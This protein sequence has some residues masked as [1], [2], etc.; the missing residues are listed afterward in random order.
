MDAVR[1]FVEN[2]LWNRQRQFGP[3]TAIGFANAKEGL[4]A[5]IIYH[6]FDPDAGVIEISAYSMR[7]DWLSRA[8]LRLIFEY[9]FHQIKC[10]LVVARISERNSRTLRIWKALGSKLHSIPELR[11]PEEAEIIATLSRD[12]WQ[13]SK[14]MR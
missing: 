14:F 13:K 6:N 5:G 12:D 1:D 7:R 8:F 9:P 3:S 2:G 11:G 4:V 10:R